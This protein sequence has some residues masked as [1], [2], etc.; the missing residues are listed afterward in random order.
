MPDSTI[1]DMDMSESDSAQPRHGMVTTPPSRGSY[2]IE[3][4]LLLEWEVVAMEGGKNF[5][6]LKAGLAHDFPGVDE[7]V[8]L[9]PVTHD[10]P[11]A[12]GLILSGGQSDKRICVNFTDDEI[13]QEITKNGKG[14]AEKWP[15]LSVTRG[16]EFTVEW[17]YHAV[18]VTRGY[19]WFITKDGWDETTRIARADFEGKN[20]VGDNHF[21]LGAHDGL[22]WSDICYLSP[23]DKHRDALQPKKITSATLPDDKYGHHVILLVWIIA[24][25]DKAFYQAFD[26]DFGA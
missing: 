11:P 10:D 3:K 21:T 5:P 6:D 24:E 18:H 25:T 14:E 20:Y 12:D 7:P 17:Q 9:D 2:A 22:M 4:G 26:V 16:T 13:I 19:R 1:E 15:R 8:H 23:F